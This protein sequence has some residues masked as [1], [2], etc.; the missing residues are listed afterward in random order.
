MFLYIWSMQH[1]I[2][3]YRHSGSQF[4]NSSF[5]PGPCGWSI[6]LMVQKSGDH[7]LRLVVYPIIYQ[8]FSTIPGGWDWDFWTINYVLRKKPWLF[9]RKNHPNPGVKKNNCRSQLQSKF[10]SIDE[11]ET[12]RYMARMARDIVQA[13]WR[14]R[15][16]CGTS[17]VELWNL[18][19]L[20]MGGTKESIGTALFINQWMW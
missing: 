6:L 15:W 14:Q 11:D 20:M 2:V 16:N 19:L 3:W 18:V 13:S 7:Q 1:P 8:G 10:D 12:A 17:T 4:L 5:S 9:T